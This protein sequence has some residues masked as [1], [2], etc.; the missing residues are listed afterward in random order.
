ML[1]N[2]ELLQAQY[3]FKLLLTL[4]LCKIQRFKD[5]LR[6]HYMII[7]CINL[8]LRIDADALFIQGAKYEAYIYH[9]D[10]VFAFVFKF[11]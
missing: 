10:Y 8:R 3:Y 6:K 5:H 2:D 1:Q 7:T 11:R 4:F 9:V